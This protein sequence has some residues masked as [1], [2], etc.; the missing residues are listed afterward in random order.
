MV[1]KTAPS[2]NNDYDQKPSLAEVSE[3]GESSSSGS[4]DPALLVASAPP[5]GF[6]L[7]SSSSSSDKGRGNSST[8]AHDVLERRWSEGGGDL[9]RTESG[10]H[11]S[12]GNISVRMLPMVLGDHPDCMIGPPVSLFR[13]Q[14]REQ[15]RSESYDFFKPPI[16]NS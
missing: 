7:T 16:G 15:R 13:L 8:E 10:R 11:I 3:S 12:W 9:L 6:R 4:K 2:E 5:G 14:F 1:G